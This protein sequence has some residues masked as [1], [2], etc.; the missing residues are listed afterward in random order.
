MQKIYRF[1]KVALTDTL[2]VL[3]LIGA[4]LFGWLP[5]PG[6]IPLFILG[7][8]LLSINH[9]WAQRYID[10]AQEYAHRV[11]DLIFIK[12]PIAQILYDVLAV[13]LMASAVYVLL[14][15]EQM[16]QLSLGI[17]LGFMALTVFL[18]NRQRWRR[19]KAR[20]KHKR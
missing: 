1:W 2:G 9:D 16:W 14:N 6:G 18:G 8:S 20:I 17:F 7:L 13:V 3:C 10:L 15:L 5:G 11:G 12:N 4:L 19:L